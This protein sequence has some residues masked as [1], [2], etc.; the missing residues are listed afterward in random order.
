MNNI[1]SNEKL[2]LI[3]RNINDLSYID[4]GELNL[5]D[6]TREELYKIIK[7]YNEVLKYVLEFIETHF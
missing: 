7:T 4:V 3:I 5:D 2:K 1:S 6:F